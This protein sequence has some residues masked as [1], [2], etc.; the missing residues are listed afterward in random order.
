MKVSNVGR[1]N[2]KPANLSMTESGAL[3]HSWRYRLLTAEE[4]IRLAERIQ[5]GDTEAVN[6]LVECN[7]RL[8]LSVA[9]RYHSAQLSYDDL[10][11]EG[12]IGLMTAAERFNP[13]IGCRFSTYAIHW[14]RQAI[15]RAID[16][17]AHTIRVPSYISETLR[18]AERIRAEMARQ[19]GDE[20]SLE[21]LAAVMGLKPARLIA[22]MQAG[23]DMVSL[24]KLVGCER[25]ANLGSLLCD[26]SVSDPEQE[27][28]RH[29]LGATL[30]N[31][32]AHLS[33]REREVLTKRLGIG[34]ADLKPLQE[35][36]ADL[37][38]SRERVRQIEAQA[39]R[40][41]RNLAL[42]GNLRE[43]LLH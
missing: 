34:G 9:R 17:N 1:L 43:I 31:L 15:G 5:R 32:L 10:V 8:V 25:S 14:I 4:E 23:Q 20:V 6:R 18:K 3:P 2:Y 16:N 33:P 28:F 13:Q 38:L 21:R 26:E 19:S 27:L 35:I 41:L 24:D 7:M 12:A 40:K 22:L 30:D 37:N 36:G 42:R 11:Q 29:E 39:I